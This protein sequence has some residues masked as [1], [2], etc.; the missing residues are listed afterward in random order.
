MATTAR[1]D[2]QRREE[3]AR[4]FVPS[5][6]VKVWRELVKEQL[7]GLEVRD[8]HDYYDFNFNIEKRCDAIAERVLSGQYRAETPLVYKVEKKLGICRHMVLPSPSDALV[9][10]VLADAL[11]EDL[12]KTQPSKKA[13]YA[14][15]RHSLRLP[16]EVKAT[17]GYPWFTLWP[18]FQ[19]E[20]WGFTSAYPIL[21][22]TDLTNYYDNIALDDLRRVVAGHIHAKE[23]LLDLLFSLIEDLAW[24][25]DYLPR[26]KK[27]LP[28]IQIEAPRLMAH[29]LLFEVDAVLKART[30]DSFVRWMDDINFGVR[31]RDD[32]V[33]TL[34]EL[35]DVLKS[36]GL[37]LNLAKTQLL[38]AKDAR[39]HFL[40]SENQRLER[41]AKRAK[42]L[43]SAHAIASFGSQVV[44]ELSVHLR[45]CDARNKDKVTKRYFS[46]L[47]TLNHDGAVDLCPK[48]YAADAGMRST[49]V[50][51]LCRLPFGTRV[52]NTLLKLLLNTR[53]VDDAAKFELVQGIVDWCVPTN[54]TGKR[55][56]QAISTA[57]CAPSSLSDWLCWF[58]F[59]SKY[60]SPSD[61]LTAFE[62]S[63]SLRRREPFLA[64]QAATLLC[65][66]VSVNA[67][68]VK[69]WWDREV[70]TGHSDSASVAVNLLHLAGAAFPGKSNRLY[71]YLFP[72]KQS[73]SYPVPKFLLL[74]V[75]AAK[76]QA[77]GIGKARPVVGHY[78]KDPWMVKELRAINASWFA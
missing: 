24:R 74:C 66:G 52:S 68:R 56:V 21:V 54:K 46:V 6:M 12:L 47:K 61:A 63:K 64:R 11:V 50:S 69:E 58:L 39:H 35:S 30:S 32:A 29:A 1:F 44:S 45:D 42:R 57:L 67:T 70:S 20:I 4:V 62:A 49:V 73:G 28:T 60:G 77:E 36:R 78:V 43:K 10:Q 27:G 72:T 53:F 26:T 34:G 23:A 5:R 48:L 37:A 16:H 3:L 40:I 18:K 71:H 9:F 17:V 41:Y 19:K 55:F 7:R 22:T 14:R 31:S 65:R 38:S 59:L 76:E 13:F 51:Y 15:D 2:V 75:I 25:P 8:L 33:R